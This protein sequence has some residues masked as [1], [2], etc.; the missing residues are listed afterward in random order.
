[1][2]RRAPSKG[3]KA[4]TTKAPRVGVGIIITKDES[5]L[6][7]RR[8]NVHGAGSWST[9]GGHLEYGESPEDCATRE[10]KEETDL[11]VADIRFK[12]IT[13]DV[14][15]AEG[16]HYITIWMEGRYTAG[17]PVVNA[18]YEMAEIGWFPWDAMP[19]PLFL[20]L[21]H[22]LENDCYPPQDSNTAR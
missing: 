12:A 2:A 4:V 20:P 13:N 5:V 11:D 17:E 18:A 1:M 21:R 9:P 15:E 22:L 19:Q 14:F 6:L 8:K 7:L 16:R 3:V 10:A